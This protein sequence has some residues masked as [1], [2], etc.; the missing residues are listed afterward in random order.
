MFE[1]VVFTLTNGKVTESTEH[2]LA[3][4]AGLSEIELIEKMKS[5]GYTPLLRISSENV[6]LW[7]MLTFTKRRIYDEK[8]SAF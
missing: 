5:L 3:D 7:A 8:I 6:E 4:M 1:S 2:L